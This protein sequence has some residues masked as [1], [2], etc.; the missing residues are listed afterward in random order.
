MLKGFSFSNKWMINYPRFNNN[1]SSIVF[2]FF[3]LILGT[4]LRFYNLSAKSYWNDEMYTVIEG[5]QSAYQIVA[6]GRLDQPPAYYLPFHL[7][8]QTFGTTEESTRSFSA[9]IGVSSIVLIYLVGRE[10]FDKRV[11]LLSALLMAVSTF[12]LYYSQIARYYIFFEFMALSSFLFFILAL[13][14][15]KKNYFALYAIA[16]ILMLYSHIFGVFILAGQNLFLILQAKKYRNLIAIWF[17]FQA[18]ILLAFLPY[19][20]IMTFQGGGLE[21]TAADTGWH[22]FIPSLRDLLR[23]VIFYIFA[24]RGN[25][26]WGIMLAIYSAA[27]AL[28]VIGTWIYAFRQGRK[29]WLVTTKVIAA[30]LQETPDLKSKLLLLTCWLTC[31]I[32]LPYVSSIVIFPIFANRYT[33]SA[34]PALYLLLAFGIYSIRKMVPI[35]ISV[36][37]LAIIITPSL[38]HYYVTPVDEQWKEAAMYVEENSGPNEVILFPGI[39]HKGITQIAFNWYYRGPSQSCALSGELIDPIAIS[40]ALMQCISGHN[41]FWVIMPDYPNDPAMPRYQLFFLGPYQTT[42]R[43]IKEHHVTKIS[44]YLFELKK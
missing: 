9:L 17:I 5:Q 22:L 4:V 11:G 26:S 44:I 29:N 7:W 19:L 20:Y 3:I 2:L 23:L 40:D 30:D 43:L 6:S 32:V 14:N 31:P 12:Q 41:R 13:R 21:G 15:K 28:L 16:S 24:P 39:I 34:A 38:G 42:M 8:E 10:L 25:R 27:G 1:S 18:V 35:I 33:I 37:V 36:G